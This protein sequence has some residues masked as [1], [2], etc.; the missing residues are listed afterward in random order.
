MSEQLSV[1]QKACLYDE[2]VKLVEERQ[3][4]DQKIYVLT[5]RGITFQNPDTTDPTSVEEK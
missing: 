4:L 3:V 5:S 2:I 1:E